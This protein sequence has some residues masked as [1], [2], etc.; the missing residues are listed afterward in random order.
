MC[1]AGLASE[2]II[3]T[4]VFFELANAGVA[5]SVVV[6]FGVPRIL[7][8]IWPVEIPDLW[9]HDAYF[10]MCIQGLY[11]FIDQF[12]GKFSIVINQ[13]DIIA[14]CLADAKIVAACK[15]EIGFRANEVNRR[16][17]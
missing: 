12:F 11:Q 17:F 4:I 7:Q 1:V 8:Y 13:E 14:N 9:G 16:I 15:A 10:G 6:H 2:V 5:G 3:L